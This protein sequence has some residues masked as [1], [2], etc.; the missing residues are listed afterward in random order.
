MP[1]YIEEGFKP[2]KHEP[3][4]TLVN[5]IKYYGR[6]V[7]DLQI[8][9]IFSDIKKELPKLNGT[10]LDIGCGQS[11]YRYLLNEKTTQYKG[12]DVAEAVSFDYINPDVTFFDGEN[13]PFENNT[14]DAIVCTEVLEH[15]FNHQKLVDEMYRVAKPN[16]K[17]IITIPFSARYHY[18]PHDYFRYTPSALEKIFSKF[19][20][21][22]VTPRGTD[23]I[24]ICAKIIVLFFR[25][26][27]PN[28]LKKIICL[29][30]WILMLP[31]LFITVVIAHISIWL[32]LGSNLDPLG[33]TIKVTK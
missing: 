29:P 28:S 17:A 14:F 32:N 11:P 10:V 20:K 1:K 21:V 23:V 30:F 8:L 24:S 5:K 33:Y 12:I 4:T 13:I 16:A 31:V 2:I 6:M 9:T 3:P 26:I 19:S 27:I 25:N 7:L 15:V 22:E 18:I